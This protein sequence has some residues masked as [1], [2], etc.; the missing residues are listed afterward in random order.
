MGYFLIVIIVRSGERIL[1]KGVAKILIIED[2]KR[3]AEGVA[4]YLANAGYETCIALDGVKGVS[5]VSEEKPDL[6]VLD[7]M[8]PGKNGFDVCKEIRQETNVPIIILTAKVEEVDKVKGLGLGADDY[9]TKPFSPRELT[10]RVKAVLRRVQGEVMGETK[11]Y[12]FGDVVLNVVARECVVGGAKKSLTPIEF[13]IL[14]HLVKHENQVFSRNQLLDAAHLGY[15]EGIER[16]VDVHIHNLRK[17]IE[18]DPSNP[19][20]ILTVFGV[21]Y[22]F[23]GGKS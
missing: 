17:K 3:I 2:E 10:A 8:L 7:L 14:Y 12:N 15:F 4:K 6:I 23:V 16:T 9:V 19:K 22:R 11:V 13:D 18:Q 20:Y 5:A 21:G 1:E